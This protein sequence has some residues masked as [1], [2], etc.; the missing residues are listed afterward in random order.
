VRRRE[1]GGDL[2]QFFGVLQPAGLEPGRLVLSDL[3]PRRL[4][5]PGPVLEIVGPLPRPGSFLSSLVDPSPEARQACVRPGGAKRGLRGAGECIEDV[6]LRVP[7]QESLVLVLPVQVDQGISEPS[8]QTRRDRRS[9]HPRPVAAFALNF[10]AQ[11]KPAI[12]DVDP[13]LFAQP[14]KLRDPRAIEHPFHHRP[15][16]ARAH[17]IRGRAFAEKKR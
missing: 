5:F 4:D 17:H 3:E 1:C 8:D 11:D 14:S 16:L 12:L 2:H 7:P 9:V 15:G 13:L 6:T 10:A